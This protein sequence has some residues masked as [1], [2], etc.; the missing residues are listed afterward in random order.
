MRSL[1]CLILLILLLPACKKEKSDHPVFS[2]Y[3]SGVLYTE[4]SGI[5]VD[6][7][8]VSFWFHGNKFDG[9]FKKAGL[10][11]EDKFDNEEYII[12][13]SDSVILRGV[14]P[15]SSQYPTPY[16]YKFDGDSLVLKKAIPTDRFHV[17]RLKRS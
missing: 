1:V 11:D 7:Y 16:G 12:R 3:Y 8:E 6:I 15:Y 2:G 5:R 9:T 10:D 14:F 4:Q 13:G 17:I